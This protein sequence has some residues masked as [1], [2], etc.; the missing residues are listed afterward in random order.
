MFCIAESNSRLK[1]LEL[2]LRPLTLTVKAFLTAS[3][4]QLSAAVASPEASGEDE[5]R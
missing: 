4:V 1:S 3:E 5:P 2:R